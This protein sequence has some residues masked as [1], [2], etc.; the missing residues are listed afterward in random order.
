[1]RLEALVQLYF[2]RGIKGKETQFI[3][4]QFA[5]GRNEQG[6]SSGAVD[7]FFPAIDARNSIIVTASA[8]N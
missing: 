8:A 6:V 2:G 5:S 3:R 1:M 4:A 7:I